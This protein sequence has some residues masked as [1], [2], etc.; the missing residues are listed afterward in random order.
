MFI[1][2]LRCHWGNASYA[3]G[4]P[5]WHDLRAICSEAAD[6]RTLQPAACLAIQ[7]D[8]LTLLQSLS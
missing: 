1:Q 6:K 3:R 4:C 7:R 5:P 2:L 8:E